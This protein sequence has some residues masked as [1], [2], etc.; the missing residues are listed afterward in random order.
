MNQRRGYTLV[1]LL[2]VIS[3]VTV[4]LTSVAVA[5]HSLFQ[6]D[7]QLRQELAD[8]ATLTRLAA[9]LRSDA[10]GAEKA[11]LM[12]GQ[13]GTGGAAF[14]AQDGRRIEYREESRRLVRT[15]R[16]GDNVEHRDVFALPDH[17]SAA[18][19]IGK[20]GAT[21][22]VSL[23]ITQQRGRIETAA[24]ARRMVSIEAAVGI[25]AALISK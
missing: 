22:L 2:V 20:E 18:W 17:A 7:K 21:T 8:A 12:A 19:K 5:L 11:E 25:E 4:A 3:I 14:T 16:R 23:A 6:V 1:E 15:A 13:T 10:H 9:R 24:D